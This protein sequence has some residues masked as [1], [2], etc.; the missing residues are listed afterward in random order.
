MTSNAEAGAWRIEVTPP[1]PSETDYFLHVLCVASRDA[2]VP[3][4]ARLLTEGQ[5]PG[6]VG[7]T[8][9]V[10]G[11]D[12][13]AL[14]ETEGAPRGRVFIEEAETGPDLSPV[15]TPDQADRAPAPR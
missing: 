9:T 6:Q 8:V 7:C 1:S 4:E 11:R 3:I 13:T 5:E 15:G 10:G 2:P 12:F 14:F